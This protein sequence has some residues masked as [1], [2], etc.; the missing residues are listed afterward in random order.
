MYSTYTSKILKRQD[1]PITENTGDRIGITSTIGQEIDARFATRKSDK[2]RLQKGVMDVQTELEGTNNIIVGEQ[3][4]VNSEGYPFVGTMSDGSAGSGIIT[5]V[6]GANHY[7]TSI[8]KKTITI[9]K[10]ETPINFL[11]A[12]EVKNNE[13]IVIFNPDFPIFWEVVL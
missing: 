3:S 13:N 2:D 11:D 5:S 4:I 10:K 7:Q 9:I 8:N 12:L 1:I 6:N